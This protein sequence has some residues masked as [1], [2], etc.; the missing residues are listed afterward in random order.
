MDLL[1]YADSGNAGAPNEEWLKKKVGV[2]AL[3]FN[4][5]IYIY[6]M[7]IYIYDT[8]IGRVNE[9]RF[10]YR[11]AKKKKKYNATGEGEKKRSVTH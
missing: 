8:N 11:F 6:I 9:S 10:V 1:A 3:Y 5:S 2:I 7:Y 4:N